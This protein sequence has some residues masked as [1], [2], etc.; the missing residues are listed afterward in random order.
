[1]TIHINVDFSRSLLRLTQRMSENCETPRNKP[2]EP[3]LS[4]A[5][6]KKSRC[7]VNRLERY[8]RVIELASG[9]QMDGA[10]IWCLFGVYYYRVPERIVGTGKK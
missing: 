5:E 10:M 2:A 3:V 4:R 9:R 1:M 8:Q 7:R 6:Q